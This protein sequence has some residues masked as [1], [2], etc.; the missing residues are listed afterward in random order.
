MGRWSLPHTGSTADGGQANTARVIREVRADVQCLVEV[1]DRPVLEDFCDHTL[2]KGI[3]PYN[4]L[5]DGNDQRGIDVGLLSKYP[6]GRIKTHVFDMDGAPRQKRIFSRDCPEIAVLLPGERPLFLLLNHFKSQGYGS[7][8]SNDA[9]R[10]AQADRVIQ[11]LAGYDLSKDLVVVAG[12]FNDKPDNDPITGLV[13]LQG[14][15]DVLAKKFPDPKDRWTY[16]DKSQI[17]YLLVYLLVSDPLASAM[18]D[19]GIERRGLY[20]LGKLTKGAEQSFDTVTSDTNYA[21]DHAA[22]WAE[23]SV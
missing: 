15:T 5:V 20:Q 3:Y 2:L 7:K 17:D 12:D 9:R 21:S 22:A 16:R 13:H 4:M 6:L 11:I 1:E 23:F 14:L 18:V 19:A 8:E 10:K